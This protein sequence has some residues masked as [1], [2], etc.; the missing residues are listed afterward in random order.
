MEVYVDDET[1]LTLHGLRQHYVKLN[2]NE[3]NRKLLDLLDALEFNQVV[4]FV[5][6]VQR[7][8]ALAGL[9]VEQN[10]PA[11]A[12]HRTMSQEERL[13]R[14]QQFKNFQKR[15][16]VATNLFGRGMDIERVNIVFNYDMPE[17]SD[18]YLHR[19]ARAG[20]FGTKGLAITFV[21]DEADVKVLNQI[22]ERFVVNI[23]E[24]PDEIDIS[25]YSMSTFFFYQYFGSILYFCSCK[26]LKN[27]KDFN[28]KLKKKEF[29]ALFKNNYHYN[30]V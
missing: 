12:I 7:C 13:S 22:Q 20:R 29:F 25:T 18:T 16:L 11:I 30:I 9:L 6:S 3:K 14:Y 21:S 10:F 27:E 1:K 19:V 28:R 24:L 5:K 15:I 17:D 2:E 4:I 8:M 26:M 23:T